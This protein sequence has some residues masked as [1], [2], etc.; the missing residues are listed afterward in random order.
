MKHDFCGTILPNQVF[1]PRF[2][3]GIEIVVEGGFTIISGV[4]KKTKKYYTVN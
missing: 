4:L 2:V 3:K 1:A